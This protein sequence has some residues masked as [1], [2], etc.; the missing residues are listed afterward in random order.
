[1]LRNN[2]IINVTIQSKHLNNYPDNID[3]IK[4]SY[5]VITYSSSSAAPAIVEGKPLYVKSKNCYFYD[6][7]CGDFKDIENPINL[8]DRDK[9]FLKYAGTHYNLQDVEN[10]YFFG[11]VKNYI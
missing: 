9:W 5:A 10:G 11:L 2:N 7:D 6:M 3:V 8:P 1:L 4:N